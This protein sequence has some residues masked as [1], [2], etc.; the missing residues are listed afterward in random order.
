MDVNAL[1]RHLEAL[2]DWQGDNIVVVQVPLGNRW[3][4][5]EAAEDDGDELRLVAREVDR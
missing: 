3:Y 4:E 5:V 2:D 1:K